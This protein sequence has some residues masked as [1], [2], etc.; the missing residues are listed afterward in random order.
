MNLSFVII[1]ENSRKVPITLDAQEFFCK[2]ILK[3]RIE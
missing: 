2:K 3:E 1:C